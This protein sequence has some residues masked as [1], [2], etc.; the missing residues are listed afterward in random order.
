MFSDHSTMTV[1]TTGLAVTIST[2]ARIKA[3]LEIGD[4]CTLQFEDGSSVTLELAS[5]RPGT[6]SHSGSRAFAGFRTHKLFI[7]AG[8]QMGT[9]AAICRKRET[10]L[11]DGL[12]RSASPTIHLLER[13]WAKS[14]GLSQSLN[15][16]GPVSFGKP[17]RYTT[18]YFRRLRLIPSASSGI[19]TAVSADRASGFDLDHRPRCTQI[20]T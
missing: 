3:V 16:S 14:Y 5:V 20:T 12:H 15:S 6:G 10:A 7:S 8:V 13:R 9:G 11:H 2:G 4:E 19:P 18:A 17:A 1:K